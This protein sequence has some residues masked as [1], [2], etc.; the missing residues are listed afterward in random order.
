MN[1][2]KKSFALKLVYVEDILDF[3]YKNN[4]CRYIDIFKYCNNYIEY[5]IR[6]S[7]VCFADLND[8]FKNGNPR[9][10]N[11]AK[12]NSSTM[13]LVI[14][15]IKKNEPSKFGDYQITM[16]NIN[17]LLKKCIIT[18]SAFEEIDYKF[19]QYLIDINSEKLHL[20]KTNG[21]NA[22]WRRD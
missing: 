20:L 13:K 9:H 11:T 3:G 7:G 19:P 15:V 8:F 5:V 1:T 6:E 22:I 4:G 16:D 2:I 10:L 17:T 12:I 14:D 18:E 21:K